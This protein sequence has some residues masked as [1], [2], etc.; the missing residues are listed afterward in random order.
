MSLLGDLDPNKPGPHGVN[1]YIKG[2]AGAFERLF[3]DEPRLSRYVALGWSDHVTTLIA[4]LGE[5]DN[6]AKAYLKFNHEQNA[7]IR[8][9]VANRP[10]PFFG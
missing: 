3:P 1:K 5:W 2:Y 6:D 4:S 7:L 8:R 9:M 10:D